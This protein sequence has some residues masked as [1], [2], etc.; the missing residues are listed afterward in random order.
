MAVNAA[1]EGAFGVVQV[2]SAQILKSDNFPESGECF[3]ARLWRT[4][5]VSG[6]K[7]MAGIDT[8]ANARLIFHAVDDGG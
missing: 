1:T 2:H 3:F 4:Q 7:G 6:G 5:I 8:D